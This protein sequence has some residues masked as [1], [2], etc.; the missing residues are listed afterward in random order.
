VNRVRALGAVSA[1]QLSAG[2]TGLALALR[3]RRAYHLPLLHGHP[4]NVARDSLVLGTA[5]SPPVAMIGVQAVATA[6][7]LRGG[8]DGTGRVLGALGAVMTV[9]YLGEE[10]VRRRL[11][12][13]G[14][15]P[16]ESPVVV[17]GIT[18]AAMMAGLGLTSRGGRL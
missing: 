4:D 11:L 2:M 3:R 17:L 8:Q 6:R 16:V 14:W 7:A 18:T 1:V 9:G 5:F 12:R 10:L 15:D 13:T